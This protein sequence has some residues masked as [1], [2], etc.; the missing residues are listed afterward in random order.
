LEG[1]GEGIV[2]AVVVAELLPLPVPELVPLPVAEAGPDG[3]AGADCEPNT[4]AVPVTHALALRAEEAVAVSVPAAVVLPESGALTAC[5][6]VGGGEAPAE[7]LPEGEG[8][9]GEGEVAPEPVGAEAEGGKEALPEPEG[10]AG[11]GEGAPLGEPDADALEAGV[12]VSG[13]H[14]TERR[15]G[16]S[17]CARNSTLSSTDACKPIGRLNWALAAGPFTSPPVAVPASVLTL[18]VKGSMRRTRLL[19]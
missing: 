6:V 4:E 7:V 9:A 5:E 8:G 12:A 17:D 11:E 1:V 18:P 19:M 13:E 14:T 15:A 10:G 2:D 16:E 3:G